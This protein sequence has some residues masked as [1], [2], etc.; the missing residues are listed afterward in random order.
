MSSQS[1]F[2]SLHVVDHPVV[3]DKLSRLRDV[4]CNKRD[5]KAHLY[6]IS[7]L[8]AYEITKD[9][10]TETV[11]VQTPLEVMDGK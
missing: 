1:Q 6:D 3:Q 9:L 11:K 8:M 2:P 4:S 10:E 7:L 5:F